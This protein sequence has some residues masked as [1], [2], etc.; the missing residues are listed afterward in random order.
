MNEEEKQ[1]VGNWALKRKK[2]KKRK[3]KHLLPGDGMH[4][5]LFQEETRP[6]V[7]THWPSV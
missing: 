6:T 5:G 7:G 3:K 4:R 2:K 1:R